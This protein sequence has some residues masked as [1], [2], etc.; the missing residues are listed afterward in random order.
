MTTVYFL[1][2]N[3]TLK[4]EIIYQELINED[5]KKELLPLSSKGEEIANMWANNKRLLESKNI[6]TSNSPRMINSAKYL[7]EMLDLPIFIDIRLNER[8]VGEL[9]INNEKFLKETQSHDYDY[10]LKNGESMNETKE[11]M[12]QCLKELLVRHEEETITIFTHDIAI[13]SLFHTWCESGFNLENQQIL[14]FKEE[15]IIDGAYHKTRLFCVTFDKMKVKEIHWL[16][17]DE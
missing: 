2:N 5:Q 7:S 6:Y 11:R 1:T 10:K 15:V 9:G 12:K 13:Q 3:Y 16:N 14:N 17:K 8:K 4:Q